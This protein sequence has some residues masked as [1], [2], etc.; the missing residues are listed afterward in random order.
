[1]YNTKIEIGKSNPLGLRRPKTRRAIICL[2]GGIEGLEIIK[3]VDASGYMPI[4]VDVNWQSPGIQWARKHD[5]RAMSWQADVYNKNSVSTAIT[6]ILNHTYGVQNIIDGVLCCAVDASDSQAV[7]AEKYHWPTIGVRQAELAKDKFKQYEWLRDHNIPVPPTQLA[8]FNTPYSSEYN[9]V[10]PLSGRGARGV[11]RYDKSNFK[12]AVWRAIVESYPNKG[13]I[14]QKWM[15]GLQLS[16]ESVIYNN[17][18][19]FTAV[20]L[21]NYD[22]LDSLYPYVIENGSDTPFHLSEQLMTNL[23]KLIHRAAVWM[24]WNDT[25]VKCDIVLDKDVFYIIE[26]TPRLSGGYFCSHIIPLAYG[27]DVVDAAIQFAVGKSRRWGEHRLQRY[28]SQRFLFPKLEWIG[29]QIK[30]LPPPIADEYVG[31]FTYYR[32]EGDKIVE[33]KKHSDRLAQCTVVAQTAQRSRDLCNKIID[34]I[35]AGIVVE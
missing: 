20:A 27:F 7:L 30:H 8:D 9:V 29:K 21:R 25:T 12:S 28:V 26:M 33:V 16:T 1:M 31:I 13:I 19:I 6:R 32:K 24:N 10:K 35:E 18:L 2:G 15:D 34:D 5:D 4:V 17:Q 23:N 14:L 3:Q 11:S 22:H